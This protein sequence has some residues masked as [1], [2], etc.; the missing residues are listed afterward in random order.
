VTSDPDLAVLGVLARVVIAL[1]VVLAISGLLWR[2]ASADTVSRICRNLIV[3]PSVPM[4]SCFILEPSKA[5][6]AALHDG[7]Q[8][9]RS[10]RP[11]YF[12]TILHGTRERP[13]WLRGG[14]NAGAK[15][16]PLCLAIDTIYQF[17]VLGTFHPKE[18][19]IVVVL[20]AF[21]TYMILQG[22]ALRV[23]RGTEHD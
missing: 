5:T 9:A 14:L 18:P 8:D 23:W 12:W 11:P 3:R 10:G 15:I 20:L 22:Q 13:G 4:N 1:A 16:I 2:G 7:V 17:L 19:L 6:I 21:V